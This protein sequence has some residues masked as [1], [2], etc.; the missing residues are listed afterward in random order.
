MLSPFL[1]AMV[2]TQGSANGQH[3]RTWVG[4]KKGS[5]TH[6]AAASQEGILEKKGAGHARGLCWLASQ[7]LADTYL[8]TLPPEGWHKR[9][10]RWRC[11]TSRRQP[12]QTFCQAASSKNSRDPLA[13]QHNHS[14]AWLQQ[15]PMLQGKNGRTKSSTAMAQDHKRAWQSNFVD[16]IDRS[17]ES[18]TI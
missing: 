3:S 9:A 1:H 11:V 8:L 18:R 6:T 16:Q 2:E 13:E 5:H 12:Q 4:S 14:S 17:L 15:G 7:Q 10:T